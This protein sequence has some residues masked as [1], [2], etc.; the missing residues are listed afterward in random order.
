MSSELFEWGVIGVLV[1]AALVFPLLFFISAPY[2]RHSRPGWGPVLPAR[3]GWVLMEL[4]SPICFIWMF[5]Q[6][7]NSGNIVP[8][9]LAAMYLA[10]YL[11]RA[12]IYPLRMRGSGKTNPLLTVAMAFIF[13]IFNGSL[14]GW[15]ISSLGGHLTDSWLTDPRFLLGVALFIIGATINLRSDAALRR[16]RKPGD[17]GYSIP[18]TGLHR[19]VASPNYFGEI[20][21]W[22][23][24]ALAAWTLPAATFLIFTI[25]NLAP[26]ARDNLHWYQQTF[27]D[28]PPERRALI[29]KVW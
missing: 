19:H 26:R 27:D 7:P 2:G 8:L 6:G 14:N 21:E 18:N 16:L 22:T 12:F 4:P 10:H 17:S 29:P 15:A 23:G 1:S 11:Y 9:M 3:L 24:F 20:I 28:Y 25:A 13:N 5:L